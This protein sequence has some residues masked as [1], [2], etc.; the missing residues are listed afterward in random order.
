MNAKVDKRKRIKP[1]RKGKG[2]LETVLII[3]IC[4][5]MV[6]A[7]A[8][9]IGFLKRGSRGNVYAAAGQEALSSGVLPSGMEGIITSVDDAHAPGSKVGRIGT[10]CENVLVGQRLSPAEYT[11]RVDLAGTMSNS[12]NGLAYTADSLVKNAKLMSDQDYETL[13]R[14]VEAEAGEDDVKG[15][16]LVANVIMNRV[17][18]DDFPNSVYDVVFQYV[19]G[20][21]QFSPTYDG[22]IYDVTVTDDTKEAVKMAL[23]G[24]DYSD[25][26]LFFIQKSAAEEHNVSWFE[27]DL[28]K[29]FKYGV[30]E[31]Y[32][33]PEDIDM[34]DTRAAQADTAEESE[35][36]QKLAKND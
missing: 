17:K 20:V 11:T 28:K 33:Y 15:R 13:L 2:S 18:R 10:S 35:E 16:V 4:A 30:H 6:L 19:N 3:S 27:T 12:V 9:G 26:A 36:D 23:E 5:I 14:I 25:G 22:S 32:T 29:L 1:G 21:P 7:G 31:F 8:I 34:V 24:T